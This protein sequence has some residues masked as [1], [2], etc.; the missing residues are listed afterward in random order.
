MY[1][2]YYSKYLYN[3]GANYKKTIVSCYIIYNV[4]DMEKT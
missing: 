2:F 4:T 1:N 3:L